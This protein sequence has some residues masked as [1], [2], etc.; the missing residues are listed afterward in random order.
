MRSEKLEESTGFLA[1]YA[2]FQVLIVDLNTL[3]VVRSET[4]MAGQVHV[5]VLG[6][7][8]VHPW[9]SMD[10]GRKIEVLQSLLSEELGR[11]LPP[12][13]AS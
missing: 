9:E 13:L 5:P 4:A 11:V 3:Q 2:Y 6:S 7:R 10:N 12:L 1:P 8:A